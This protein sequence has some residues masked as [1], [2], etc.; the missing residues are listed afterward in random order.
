MADFAALLG[1]RR[2]HKLC[3]QLWRCRL[4]RIMA[5]QT[6]GRGEGLVL[7]SFL[8]TLLLRIVAIQAECRGRLGQMELVLQRWFR[9]GLVG[10]MARVAAHIKRRVTTALFWHI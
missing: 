9:T 4:V 7:M 3:H 8:Q 5:L 10:D 6:V 2:M 1:K